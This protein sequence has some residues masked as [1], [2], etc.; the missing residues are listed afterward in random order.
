[1]GL[2]YGERLQRLGAAI[3]AV[4][5]AAPGRVLAAAVVALG[6]ASVIKELGDSAGMAPDWTR[7]VAWIAGFAVVGAFLWC[8]LAV[9]RSWAAE[10][11][12]HQVGPDDVDHVFKPSPYFCHVIDS[13]EGARALTTDV[14]SKVFPDANIPLP[15]V[16]AAQRH[17]NRR[18]LALIER[19]SGNTVGWAT[20]WPVR[21][22]AGR[23]VE[24]GELPDDQLTAEDVLPRAENGKAQYVVVL[25]VGLLPSHR[26]LPGGTLLRTLG[27][28]LLWHIHE[29]FY[30][31][32]QKRLN[33]L[34]I[35]DSPQGRRMCERIGLAPNG[36][37]TQFAN[38]HDPKPVYSAEMSRRELRERIH[39]LFRD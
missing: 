9:W 25:A 24:S 2:S 1:M 23:A 12:G 19:S 30:E 22:Q 34:A 16:E 38:I 37:H 26:N 39:A 10:P 7:P 8:A 32:D 14:T 21:A 13:V 18:L 3:A 11:G 20:V 6:I 28:E 36:A 15:V 5:K 4:S 17:N 35:G 31:D 29:E 27:K 33:I